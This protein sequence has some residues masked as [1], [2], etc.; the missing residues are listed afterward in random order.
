MKLLLNL[1]MKLRRQFDIPLSKVLLYLLWFLL[2]LT[3]VL[4]T[5]EETKMTKEIDKSTEQIV[6]DIRNGVLDYYFDKE[7]H[8]PTSETKHDYK[9]TE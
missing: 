1:K 9:K 5:V 7:K 8:E 3:G 6:E 4:T 2:T